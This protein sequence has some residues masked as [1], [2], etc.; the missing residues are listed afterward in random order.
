MPRLHGLLSSVGPA[1]MP[2]G[3]RSQLIIIRQGVAI[4]LV[5]LRQPSV[6]GYCG[7]S[8]LAL[9]IGLLLT[10]TSIGLTDLDAHSDDMDWPT[11]VCEHPDQITQ[12]LWY[13]ADPRMAWYAHLIGN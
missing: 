7:P 2:F 10:L 11:A 13:E 12:M 6:F 1:E 9:T 4:G 5:G 3:S 8:T